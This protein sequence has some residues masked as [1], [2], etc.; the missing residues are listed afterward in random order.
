MFSSQ[1]DTMRKFNLL[2]LLSAILIFNTMISCSE[3]TNIRSELS[4]VAVELSKRVQNLSNSIERLIDI[5]IESYESESIQDLI[6]KL[7]ITR[8]ILNFEVEL[9][10]A[11][12]QTDY[13]SKFYK[14][15]KIKL[16]SEKEIIAHYI[17]FIEK[18]YGTYK[19]KKIEKIVRDSQQNLRM[20]IKAIDNAL[21]ILGKY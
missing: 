1:G 17:N 14:N 13:Q 5:E 20:T 4:T 9:L 3:A 8:L 11:P 10:R 18:E 15:R 7:T 21:T 16:L 19:N 12:I 2:V 6:D